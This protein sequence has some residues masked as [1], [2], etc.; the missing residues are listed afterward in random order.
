MK[1]LEEAKL[2]VVEFDANVVT[3]TSG[4]EIPICQTEYGCSLDR[5]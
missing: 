4:I 5:S 3:T 2:N 1:N